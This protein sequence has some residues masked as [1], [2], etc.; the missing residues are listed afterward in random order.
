M[1]QVADKTTIKTQTGEQIIETVAEKIVRFRMSVPAVLFLE[2]SKPMSVLGSSALVFF[3][4]FITLFVDSTKFYQ[5]TELLEDREN[6]EKVISAI[7]KKEEVF[8]QSRK[9]AEKSAKPVAKIINHKSKVE[10]D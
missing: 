3:G 1:E 5:F 9:D 6:I 8:T 2:M 10:N 7:E 4:P